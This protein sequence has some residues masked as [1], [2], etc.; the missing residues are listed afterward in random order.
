M[1]VKG[2]HVS[3]A[4]SWEFRVGFNAREGLVLHDLSFIEHAR[5]RNANANASAAQRVNAT[6]ELVRR[7]VI[8]RASMAEMTVP[9]GD[10]RQQHYRKNAFDAGEYRNNIN[11]YI[12]LY[13]YF[14]IL[15][16][17]VC[18]FIL[19]GKDT[20]WDVVPIH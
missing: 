16:L 6:H 13:I 20:E 18:L 12:L 10:P 3:W 9:Y 11:I 1:Q 2:N 8:F 5:P 14:I 17:R 19:T 7:N 4:D 15:I